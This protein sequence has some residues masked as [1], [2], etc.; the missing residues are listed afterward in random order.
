MLSLE[1]DK[2]WKFLTT[3]TNFSKQLVNLDIRLLTNYYKSLGYY[4]VKINST[5]QKLPKVERLI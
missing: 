4:N 3:N 1:E 2:F 5:T